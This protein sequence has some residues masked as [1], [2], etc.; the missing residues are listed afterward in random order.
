MVTYDKYKLI[1][2]LAV[3]IYSQCCH[4]SNEYEILKFRLKYQLD[5]S[6]LINLF[7]LKS[8]KNPWFYDDF[9]EH[10]S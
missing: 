9:R 8:S 7:P 2:R 10:K 3:N 1:N 4:H 5:L 6:E